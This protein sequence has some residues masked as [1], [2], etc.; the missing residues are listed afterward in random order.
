MQNFLTWLLW[1]VASYF[2]VAPW[3]LLWWCLGVEFWFVGTHHWHRSQRK[4]WFQSEV[5]LRD[6]QCRWHQTA[7]WHRGSVSCRTVCCKCCK[8]PGLALCH[9]AA[10]EVW[11]YF[12]P[13]Q[14]LETEDWCSLFPAQKP[15]LIR[16]WR[17]V[18]FG[19]AGSWAIWAW[20]SLQKKRP[21]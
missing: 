9:R 6:V 3:L 20:V 8:G 10:G 14:G 13:R 11:W 5:L 4:F 1:L 21:A 15:C 12:Q 19:D 2:F 7:R 17:H 18:L 16:G